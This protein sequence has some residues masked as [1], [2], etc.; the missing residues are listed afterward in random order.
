MSK[1][2]EKK[3]EQ[4]FL[5]NHKVVNSLDLYKIINE[6]LKNKNLH[7]QTSAQSS[8]LLKNHILKILPTFDFREKSLGTINT[9]TRTQFRSYLS[10]NFANAKTLKQKIQFINNLCNTKDNNEKSIEDLLSTLTVLK[11]LEG[12]VKESTPGSAG[13]QFE[14]LIAAM[15]SSGQQIATGRTR[16]AADIIVANENYQ[17]KLI[18]AG[19]SATVAYSNMENYFFPDKPKETQN[20]KEANDQQTLQQP[21]EVKSKRL[22]FI[23]VEKADNNSLNFYQM[24]IT[25]EEYKYLKDSLI[26]KRMKKIDSDRE[27][28]QEAEKQSSVSAKP[29]QI[30]PSDTP[31][32]INEIKIDPVKQK[33]LANLDLS[34]YDMKELLKGD[35]YLPRNAFT[36]N[37]IGTISIGDEIFTFY[38]QKLKDVFLGVFDN[39]ALL[40]D[41]VNNF[42]IHNDPNAGMDAKKYAIAVSENIKLKP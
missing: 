3:I 20:I 17:I 6:H 2:F 40:I 22:G 24:F 14:A 10:K 13:Y 18:K 34:K 9:E 39:L 29:P 31:K 12:I 8:Q 15:F 26:Q 4:L 32:E 21:K 23:I 30:E 41:N 25:T 1:E 28:K 5:D 27:K 42:Y 11:I 37:S 16:N 7:E 33:Q 19:G 38:N 35:F 36:S